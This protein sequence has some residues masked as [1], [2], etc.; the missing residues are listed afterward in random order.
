MSLRVAIAHDWL[1]NYAGSER[2]VEQMLHLFPDARLL[3]SVIDRDAVPTVFHHAEPSFLQRIPGATRHHEYL[4]PLMPLAWRLRKPID[5]VDI[6]ISS[7][8]ACA[9]AVR[10]APGIPHLCYCHAPMRY[11]WNFELE[12]ER[13]PPSLRPAVRLAMAAFRRWDRAKA[14][15]VTRFLANS[16]A[17][18]DRIGRAY[19]R[20]AVVVHPPVDTD[21]FHP[22]ARPK[23]SFFLSVGRLVAYKRPD[24]VVRA[25]AGS[26]HRLV[27]AGD[28]PLRKL[29]ERE[30]TSNVSFVGSVDDAALRELYRS[31]RALVF[32]GEE[33]FGIVM[34]EALA[35]GTPVIALDRGGARD[36]VSDAVSGRLVANAGPESLLQAA[37]SLQASAS[38][39][40]RVAARAA[41][42]SRQSFRQRLG[43]HAQ[44][45]LAA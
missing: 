5:D 27:V 38:E 8:H 36:I 1:V 43:R 30:A 32:L 11:A 16:T 40:D 45:L 17:I 18:A 23:E 2:V 35:C 39:P 12:R 13:F 22:S 25:F 20:D 44:E 33:D 4:L 31:A 19:G 7:S 24:A 3:T 21:F 28:G 26:P 41:R 34:A 15:G 42:F 10:V 29:L 14:R 37:A 9:K 6:V